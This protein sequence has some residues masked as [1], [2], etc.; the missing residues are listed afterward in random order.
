MKVYSSLTTVYLT[1]QMNNSDKSFYPMS[2][3]KDRL[4]LNL[5]AIYLPLLLTLKKPGRKKQKTLKKMPKKE[6]VE[7]M[8]EVWKLNNGQ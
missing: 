1:T 4:N 7:K 6:K 2:K 8:K 5:P 3:K